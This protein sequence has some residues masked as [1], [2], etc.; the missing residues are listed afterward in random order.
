MAERVGTL[1][2]AQLRNMRAEMT[3]NAEAVTTAANR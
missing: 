2:L 1:I 3:M